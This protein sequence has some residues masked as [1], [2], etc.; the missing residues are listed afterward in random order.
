MS[1]NTSVGKNGGNSTTTSTSIRDRDQQETVIIFNIKSLPADLQRVYKSLR[2]EYGDE[3]ALTMIFSI[4]T[5]VELHRA[6]HMSLLTSKILQQLKDRF[7]Y[8]V[9]S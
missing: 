7:R 3:Y 9:A 2:K 5:A 8:V 1:K 4:R 6:W